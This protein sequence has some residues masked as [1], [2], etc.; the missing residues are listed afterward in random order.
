ME[1]IWKDIEGFDNLY[2]VSNFGNVRSLRHKKLFIMKPQQDRYGY[3]D[4]GLRICNKQKWFTIHR[5]VAEAFI[6]NPNN[7]P[8]VNHKDEDKTNN[9]VTNLEWCDA[10]YNNNYGTVIDRISK[11]LTNRKDQSKPV[12][13]YDKNGNFIKEYPS[14]MDAERKTGI[15]HNII[16]RVCK[17]KQRTS[18]G[19]IWKYK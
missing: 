14:I 13:Q 6:E 2:Q 1:E 18:G 8:Q 15:R 10:K 5:L 4:V 7:L 16:C 9:L 17:G 19:Y 12:L 3:L 11:A